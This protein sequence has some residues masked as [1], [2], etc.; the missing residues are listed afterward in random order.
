MVSFSFWQKWLLAVSGIIIFFGL[1]IA[2]LSWSPVFVVFNTLVNGTFW[3]GTGPDES[4]Q[5]F[6]LWAYGMLGATMAGWGLTLAFIVNGPFGKKE[7]WSRDA[8]AAGVVL[9]F[10]IDTFMSVYTGAYFNVGVNV[11]VLVLAGLPLLMT[12]KEFK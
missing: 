6:T 11:L 3:P 1:V 2:L 9:W 10:V 5:R 12:L 4:I 7:K 8:I